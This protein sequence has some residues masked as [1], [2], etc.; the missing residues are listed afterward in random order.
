MFYLIVD[1][2]NTSI[3]LA[4]FNA[5]TMKHFKQL[6]KPTLK[7]VKA[8][9]GSKN[10]EACM[11]ANVSNT[12]K[13]IVSYL[14]STFSTYNI[15]DLRKQ[16]FDFGFINTYKTP[17][18]L[19]A[20]RIANA[21]AAAMLYPT[22]NVLL[23]DMGT[24]LKVD[25]IIKQKYL[26]GSI[27]PGLTMRFKA[28]NHFTGQLPLISVTTNYSYP[29]NNTLTS[30]QSGVQKGFFYETESHINHFKKLY[31]PLHIILTGG[32]SRLF[33]RHTKKHIFADPFFTLKGLYFILINYL[34][35]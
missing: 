20:D 11:L 31:K 28:L 25:L 26:G 19:G 7:Q 33:A 3:K 2:G 23:I 4:L 17:L 14:Q 32:D 10:I 13:T 21:T 27:S 12:H 8:F 15:S 16:K 6:N 5:K 9:I 29:G 24:C 22:K 34:N 18:T 1:I 30:I 35:K